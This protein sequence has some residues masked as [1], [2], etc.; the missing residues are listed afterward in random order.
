GLK[1]EPYPH[2]TE[3]FSLFR[4]G[5]SILLHSPTGSGKSEAAFVPFLA[6]REKP[7]FPSRLLYALPMRTLVDSLAA[8]FR[9][10]AERSG[11]LVRVAAQHGRRPESV[12][13]YADAVVATIDQLITSY[14]CA[15]LN[16]GVRH[17]NIPAG[18]VASSLLVF[19]EVHTFDPERALQAMLLIAGRLRQMAVPVV[20]MTATLP[21]AARELLCD[22][23]NLTPVE[24][25]E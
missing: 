6:C 14:A 8:R 7:E 19:D 23:L 21:K 25:D 5:K 9:E 20:V 4:E 22:R 10:M 2:Q 16:L 24:V 18:A 13:F 12:L 15:P 3:A 11:A 1:D 17:G